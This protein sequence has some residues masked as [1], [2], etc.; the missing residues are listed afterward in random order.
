M[1]A[2]PAER[3]ASTDPPRAESER[4]VSVGNARRTVARTG[5][6]AL[7]GVARERCG[8]HGVRRSRI[9]A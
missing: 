5:D 7:R 6:G 4:K 2:Q 9:W 8:L 3:R 1:R